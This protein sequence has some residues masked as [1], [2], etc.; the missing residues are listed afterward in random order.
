MKIANADNR[1]NWRHYTM[2]GVVKFLEARVKAEEERDARI[3]K[4][5]E[6]LTV[7]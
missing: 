3:A 5:R 7:K 6:A 2:E 4:E 1:D